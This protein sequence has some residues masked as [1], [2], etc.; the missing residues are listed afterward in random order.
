VLKASFIAAVST[1]TYPP[2]PGV[3]TRVVLTKPHLG[4]SGRI[5]GDDA[6]RWYF[7]LCQEAESSLGQGHSVL[8]PATPGSEASTENWV[9]LANEE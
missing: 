5:A 4:G 2:H 7:L 6:I 3:E 8:A 1:T 9:T